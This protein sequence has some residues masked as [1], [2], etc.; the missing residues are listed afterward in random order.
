M[1]IL[2]F[3][4]DGCLRKINRNINILSFFGEYIMN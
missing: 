1:D 4:I 3:K 2:S